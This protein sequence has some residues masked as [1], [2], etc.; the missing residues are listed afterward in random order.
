MAEPQAI[1]NDVL[2][3]VDDIDFLTDWLSAPE[4]IATGGETY[5]AVR[6]RYNEV[7]MMDQDNPLP[8]WKIPAEYNK[9]IL[10]KD[11]GFIGKS[12]ER[13]QAVVEEHQRQRLQKAINSC[14]SL[15]AWTLCG[16]PLKSR[17]VR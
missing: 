12:G 14:R 9:L 5:S 7:A 2:S 13:L 10:L 15:T 3:P 11:I 1:E 4:N 6:Q 8:A 17:Q 16:P